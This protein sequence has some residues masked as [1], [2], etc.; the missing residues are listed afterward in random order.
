MQN[1]ELREFEKAAI[2]N[3]K[4][5]KRLYMEMRLSEVSEANLKVQQQIVALNRILLSRL[6]HNLT[7]NF[8]HMLLKQILPKIDFGKYLKKNNPPQLNEF[9]LKKPS[10]LISWIP[11][12]RNNYQHKQKSLDLKYQHLLEEYETQECERIQIVEDKKYQHSENIKVITAKAE[13]HN[14]SIL[15]WQLKYLSGES[16]AVIAYYLALLKSSEYPDA[17]PKLIEISYVKE[18]KLLGVD[19]NLPLFE[20]SVPKISV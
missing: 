6:N 14:Q 3:E 11:I 12:I 1:T 20:E 17:F 5:N 19:F 18:S 8:D 10:R 4:D 9:S 13:I 7:V 15:S 16:K 2:R